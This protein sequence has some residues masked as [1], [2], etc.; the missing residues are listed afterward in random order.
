MSSDELQPAQPAIFDALPYYDNELEQFPALRQKVEQELAREGKPP[1]TLHPRVPP[2]VELFVN[3][4]LLQEEIRRVEAREPLQPLDTLRYQLPAPTSTPGS[5]EEWQAALKNAQAQ[6][7]HQK[8]R[9]TN[10]ALLQQYGSNAWRIHNYLLEATAKK[11]E[12]DLE[13]L[14]QMTTELNRERKNFQTRLGAELTSLET[15]WTELIS[16]VLQIE[17]ANVALEAELER[18]NRQEVQLSGS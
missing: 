17:M 15:R 2:P 14:K 7:E 18:L 5:D 13:E 16:T 11:A 1:E 4:P 12:K 6:L 8:I 10:L 3:N 9:Q